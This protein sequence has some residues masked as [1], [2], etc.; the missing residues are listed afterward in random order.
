MVKGNS[1]RNK[2]RATSTAGN[3]VDSWRTFKFDRAKK[4]TDQVEVWL[5]Q[6]KQQRKLSVRLEEPKMEIRELQETRAANEPDE[7][8][9]QRVRNRHLT[10][11][12]TE[13]GV[14][15]V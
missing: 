7:Q 4:Q 10:R 6:G 11:S 12:S 8:T 5:D 2:S 14:D 1:T 13:A 15:V 9:K 3:K